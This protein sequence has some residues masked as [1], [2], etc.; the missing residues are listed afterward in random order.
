[1]ARDYRYASLV[2]IVESYACMVLNLEC[3][4]GVYRPF[5]QRLARDHRY[6][7]I[8]LVGWIKN[9]HY[10][11]PLHWKEYLQKHPWGDVDS[12]IY[13]VGD[14]W[15]T[16]NNLLWPEILRPYTCQG[17]TNAHTPIERLINV[18]ILLR[19][20][21]KQVKIM[22]YKKIWRP[23]ILV[24]GLHRLVTKSLKCRAHSGCGLIIIDERG[25]G[26]VP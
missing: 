22:K 13:D 10:H 26:H 23:S 25:M 17:R 24:R 18:I 1:M 6:A 19:E 11:Q 7:L 15:H 16:T 5:M 20:S 2:L 14:S 9:N 8:I 3:L 21:S 12:W 4:L